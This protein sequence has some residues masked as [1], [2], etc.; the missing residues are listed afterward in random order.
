MLVCFLQDS[1]RPRVPS[2][3]IVQR[4]NLTI[5]SSC[6]S[7]IQRGFAWVIITPSHPILF[8]FCL[9]P[10]LQLVF[11]SCW[12]WG[13]W[14]INKDLP[15]VDVIIFNWSLAGCSGSPLEILG[16]K[17]P[18]LQG[19]QLV[20]VTFH[21]WYILV[22]LWSQFYL[23]TDVSFGIALDSDIPRL[24]SLGQDRVLVCMGSLVIL[25]LCWTS[26]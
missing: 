8:C 21:I 18:F 9:F 16:T 19:S 1:R 24:L 2:A 15:A 20:I 5:E 13:F 25:L 4:F 22:V 6:F 3:S 12:N 17:L 10:S 11:A 23:F 26:N 7:A 14:L